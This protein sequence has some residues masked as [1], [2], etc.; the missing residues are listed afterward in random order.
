[1]LGERETFFIKK[2]YKY[3]I[4]KT[5]SEIDTDKSYE[6]IG[7]EGLITLTEMWV[8]NNPCLITIKKL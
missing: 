4:V 6:K 7:F 2:N 8:K 3:V 5:I 1:M